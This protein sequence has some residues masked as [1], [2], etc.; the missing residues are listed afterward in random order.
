MKPLHNKVQKL[1]WK[2]LWEYDK[3]DMEIQNSQ[4]SSLS[5]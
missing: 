2:W 4:N 3:F 1:A 5:F